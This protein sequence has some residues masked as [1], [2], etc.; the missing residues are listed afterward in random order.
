MACGVNGDTAMARQCA[1]R[2][3]Q[4]VMSERKAL[5]VSEDYAGRCIEEHVEP[6]RVKP[7][8]A[9]STVVSASAMSKAESHRVALIACSCPRAYADIGIG[10]GRPWEGKKRKRKRRKVDECGC[11]GTDDGA[12]TG[13]HPCGGEAQGRN[14]NEEMEISYRESQS[15]V[16]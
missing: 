3:D 4:S 5:G 12:M 1:S 16:V 2:N 11:R 15:C 10:L 8:A 14:V 13:A 7:R 9:V 6:S